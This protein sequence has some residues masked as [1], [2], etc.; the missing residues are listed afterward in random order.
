MKVRNLLVCLATCL[1]AIASASVI[2]TNLVHGIGR[3]SD[4]NGNRAQFSLDAGQITHNN[5]MRVSGDIQFEMPGP[6]A[7]GN[8]FVTM[9]RATAVSVVENVATFSGPGVLRVVTHSSTAQ[10]RGT[11]TVVATSNRHP[12]E[13]GLPDNLSVSF[14]PANSG[15]PTFSYTGDLTSGDIAV[16]TTL[17]Y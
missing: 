2:T 9:P 15:D 8:T 16:S 14:A 17:S 1:F 12:D 3:T 7:T 11:V 5:D 4:A 10:Y 6:T 13:A